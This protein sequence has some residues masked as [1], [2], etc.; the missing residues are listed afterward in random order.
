MRTGILS[1]V[2]KVTPQYLRQP[3]KKLTKPIPV[4]PIISIYSDG[5]FGFNPPVIE[6]LGTPKGLVISFSINKGILSFHAARE[7]ETYMF[8][9]PVMPDNAIN[10]KIGGGRILRAINYPIILDQRFHPDL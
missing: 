5:R 10:V 3:Q 4:D 7:E 9:L 1:S 6:Q 2:I 8:P